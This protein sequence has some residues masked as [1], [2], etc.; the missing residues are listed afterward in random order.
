MTI[1][2]Q[3][4]ENRHISIELSENSCS[5]IIIEMMTIRRVLLIGELLF[6]LL[7]IAELA[8]GLDGVYEECTL[9]ESWHGRWYTPVGDD[10]TMAENRSGGLV[11]TSSNWIESDNH[12]LSKGQCV[13]HRE[14]T[15]FF[16][17]K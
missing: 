4:Y 12:F 8:C 17:D 15:Y 5:M 7:F 3:E 14:N 13:E 6:L 16:Y 10:D 11:R 1:G 2:P 9:P